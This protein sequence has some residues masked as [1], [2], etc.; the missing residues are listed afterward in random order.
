MA[1]GTYRLTYT[2]VLS[3]EEGFTQLDQLLVEMVSRLSDEVLYL[4]EMQREFL[5]RRRRAEAA[6]D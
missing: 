4:R 5:I 6:M 2:S 1:G 3:L